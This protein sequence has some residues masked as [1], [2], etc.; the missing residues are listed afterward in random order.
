MKLANLKL[1]NLKNL[2]RTSSK[3][4]M[5]ELS[6]AFVDGSDEEHDFCMILQKGDDKRNKNILNKLKAKNFLIEES[7]GTGQNTVVLIKAPIATLRKFAN[8]IEYPM[9]LDPLSV[10]Q[11]CLTGDGE[12]IAGFSIEHLAEVTPFS[13]YEWIYAKFNSDILE[14]LYWRQPGCSHPFRQS[15]ALKLTG[16]IFHQANNRNAE[17]SIK[18]TRCLQSGA[19][20]GIFPLHSRRRCEKFEKAWLRY[21]YDELPTWDIKEYYGEKITLYL[22]FV[23][24]LTAFMT[25]PA[26]LGAALQILPCIAPS[27]YDGECNYICI[28]LLLV[29]R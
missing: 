24:H 1:G 10:Q 3:I 26:V 27:Q 20:R 4:T 25:I 28:A 22:V 5:S 11:A 7:D 21:P 15:V 14:E 6:D 29:E 13:P 8:D 12:H 18:I 17:E 9:L 2:R 19:I 23:D 16:L